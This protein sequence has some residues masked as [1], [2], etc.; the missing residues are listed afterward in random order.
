MCPGDKNYMSL[1]PEGTWR[2]ERNTP[3]LAGMSHMVPEG[4]GTKRSLLHMSKD[5]L[6]LDLG[7]P[8]AQAGE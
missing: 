8:V 7:S 2:M 6:S 5:I 4:V 1:P 3:I